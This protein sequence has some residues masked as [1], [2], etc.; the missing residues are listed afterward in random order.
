MGEG[1]GG[2]DPGSSIGIGNVRELDQT[3]T[4]AVAS[5]CFVIVVISIALEKALHHVGESL[6]K[7][8]RLALFEA[9]QKVKD[10]L[11]IVGFI[12][13]LLTFG[14]N[15][16][17]K[18]CI[19]VK[20]AETMLPCRL[21]TTTFLAGHAPPA[22]EHGSHPTAENETPVAE[23][24]SAPTRH[25]LWNGISVDSMMNRRFLSGGGGGSS[26]PHGKV[27]LVSTDGLHQLHI[28][29]FFLA[30]FHVVFSAITMVLGR[31]KIRGWKEWEMETESHDYEDS[32]DP[33]RFRFTHETSFVKQHTS[34]WNKYPVLFYMVSFFRQFYRSV[35]RADYLAMRHSFITVHLA[36]GSKFDFRKYIKRSLEDDF[37]VVVG[38]SPV[39]W[40]S[41]VIFLLLNVK[42]WGTMVWVSIMP[43]FIILAVGTKLQAIITT[44]ALEIKERHV[45][46]QGM[47]VV[48]LG[49]QHFWFGR[50]ALV[51]FFIH[52]TLFQNAFQ[53]IYLLWIWY[54]FGMN[55]CFHENSLVI[56]TRLGLGMGVQVL[57]SYVTLPLYAL[58]SQMGSSM[59]KSIFDDQTSKALKSWH[60]AAKKKHVKPTSTTDSTVHSSIRTPPNV[61]PGSSP[62]RSPSAGHT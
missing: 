52:F 2:E 29:I 40:A 5:V 34:S 22:G 61:T 28:F 48:Q 19:P 51:L 58:V 49:D 6:Q 42:G 39:L 50:P 35:R 44:M 4:W 36:P 10:E 17:A 45:V 33:S 26:C 53:I 46:V 62:P 25:L 55:S 16:I 24:G 7:K 23:H 20:L 11:M 59:K 37:K 27:S 18:I 54:E 38:I 8:K 41:A 13:L 43:L 12:S 56:V 15:Y 9:L 47:P 32:N 14:Q 57:C 21:E 1:G 31:E 30:A 3:P 60:N